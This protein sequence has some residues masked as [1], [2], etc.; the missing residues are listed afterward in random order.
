MRVIAD[1][2]THSRY[3]RATSENMNLEDLNH[4]GLIKGLSV[5]G[6]GDFTHDKWIRELKEKLQEVDGSGLYVLKGGGRGLRFILSCEVSTIFNYMNQSQHVHHVILT[7]KLDYAEALAEKLSRYG[8]LSVDG[9]P[10]LSLSAP[11]L[12]EVVLEVS[13]ENVIFPAHI[14]TPWYSILGGNNSFNSVEECYQDKA[15]EIFALETGLSSDPPMNWR[16]KSLDRFTLVSNSDSHSAWPWRIGREANVFELRELTYGELTGALRSKDPRRMLFTVETHPQYGKYHWTGHR[17]CGVSMP[18]EE[19]IKAGNRCPRCG[20]LMVK[21]VEQRVEELAT[22]KKGERPE[23][24][25]DFL[26]VLPLSEIISTVLG[27]G[28]PAL[29]KVWELYNLLVSKF[30]N[31]FKVLLDAEI[32]KVREMVG[33]G[34]ADIISRMREGKIQ[35][36]PGYDGVYGRLS[37]SDS[38]GSGEAYA[39]LSDTDK[40][41]LRRYL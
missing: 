11:E 25:I 3:S 34:I 5:V 18:P 24:A 36:V 23:G 40:L 28:S 31:E 14:W 7:P 13:R 27:L 8:D 4:F 26:H 29:K 2:H 32:E 38:N 9:R 17:R 16:V 10:V 39:P 6:S 19:A 15:H 21:G 20:R 37:L 33:G 41:G 1:L 22:R 35:V 12:V 30:G